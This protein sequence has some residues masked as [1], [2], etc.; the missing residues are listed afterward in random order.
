MPWIQIPADRIKHLPLFG[1]DQIAEDETGFWYST[2]FGRMWV[3]RDNPRVFVEDEN[4]AIQLNPL[5]ILV[6]AP[7]S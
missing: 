4:D 1:Y 6:R 7:A 3:D 5:A 2:P